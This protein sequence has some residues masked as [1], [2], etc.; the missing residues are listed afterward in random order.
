MATNA[1][2]NGAGPRAPSRPGARA[3]LVA[4]VR[5]RLIGLLHLVVPLSMLALA[6]GLRVGAPSFERYQLD[7]FDVFQRLEPRAYVESPVRVVDLDDASLERIGQWPW[8]RTDVAQLLVNLANAGVAAVALDIVFA[9]PD[10]TSPARVL[11]KWP[12]TPETEALLNN[13]D[14][15][16]D[17][18]AVLA[19]IIGQVSAA[20]IPVVTGFSLITDETAARPAEKGSFA[21]SGDDPRRYLP[22]YRGAVVTL[23]ELEAAASG[24]GSFSIA[25]EADSIIRRVPLLFR[26]G[27]TILPSLAAEVLRVAQGAKTFIVKSSG[28]SGETAF[29]EHTGI[30]HVK[31]GRIVV[32]T[33]AQGR[34]WIHF[35]EDVPE[36]RIPAW[37]LFAEDFDP[38]CG[39]SRK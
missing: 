39:I 29:G 5:K 13:I 20:G 33:D 15:L 3:A 1:I 21:Y 4:A 10:R 23:P 38:A 26:H 27:D 32:P 28:G 16:P 17:H 6:L 31:I 36:R 19:D 9:E 7:V 25:A 22:L 30:N 2:A 8:P 37:E 34:M 14:S 11:P 12:S 18:D 24:N 35:T